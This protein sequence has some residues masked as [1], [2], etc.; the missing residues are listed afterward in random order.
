LLLVDEVGVHPSR[1]LPTCTSS[2]SPAA[3]NTPR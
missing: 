3:T 1:T 2:W